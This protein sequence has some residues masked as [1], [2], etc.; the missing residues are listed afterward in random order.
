M[1]LNDF[2]IFMS[3]LRSTAENMVLY[4]L[5]GFLATSATMLDS[6][7]IDNLRINYGNWYNSRLMQKFINCDYF[8]KNKHI[9]VEVLN[10]ETVGHIAIA[11]VMSHGLSKEEL[12]IYLSNSIAGFMP[13]TLPN[14]QISNIDNH[15]AK[16][17]FPL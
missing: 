4:K 1:T 14:I 9:Q 12:S 17:I 16:I 6:E 7:T 5:N 8:L 2:K 3:R 15:H 10:M 11:K 13:Q